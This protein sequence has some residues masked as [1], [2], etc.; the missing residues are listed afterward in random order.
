[1]N[2]RIVCKHP[3]DLPGAIRTKY[4][5][6]WGANSW[7][8]GAKTIRFFQNVATMKAMKLPGSGTDGFDEAII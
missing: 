5:R 4:R 1:M 8:S 2:T 3:C 7:L 6:S